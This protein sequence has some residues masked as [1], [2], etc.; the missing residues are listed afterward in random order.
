MVRHYTDISAQSIERVADSCWNKDSSA[1]IAVWLKTT[2]CLHGF[3]VMSRGTP[4]A[5][6]KE[7]FRYL[8]GVSLTRNFCSRIMSQP[9]RGQEISDSEADM[10]FSS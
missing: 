4:Q 2:P 9:P 3:P 8:M 1:T 7:L 10:S 6:A 5:R